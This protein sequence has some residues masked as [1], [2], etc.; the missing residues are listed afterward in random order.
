MRAFTASARVDIEHFADLADVTHLT[1]V[2]PIF[3]SIGN[4]T[5]QA[6]SFDEFDVVIPAHFGAPQSA[7]E[8]RRQRRFSPR[9]ATPL[10]ILSAWLP[11]AAS[12]DRSAP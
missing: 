9:V 1:D 5:G 3:P 4:S 6:F 12:I 7:R 2:T 8:N 11:G 10:C